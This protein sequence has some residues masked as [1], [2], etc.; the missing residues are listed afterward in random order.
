MPGE[1][2]D[3]DAAAA[4]EWDLDE[5]ELGV[6]AAEWQ[7]HDELGSLYSDVKDRAWSVALGCYAKVVRDCPAQA[8]RW[9]PSLDADGMWVMP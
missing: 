9:R 5:A 3:R 6:R 4:A 7:L 2:G 1:A 8:E